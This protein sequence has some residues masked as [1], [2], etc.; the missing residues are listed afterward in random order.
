MALKLTS[1]LLGLVTIILAFSTIQVSASMTCHGNKMK[2][3]KEPGLLCR[4]G[5]VPYDAYDCANFCSCID[6]KL[7]CTAPDDCG[8]SSMCVAFELD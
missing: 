2:T 1:K 7:K 8:R 5:Y 3:K 4:E 6:G